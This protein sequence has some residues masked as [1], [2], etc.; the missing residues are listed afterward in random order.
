MANED[1]AGG[2]TSYYRPRAPECKSTFLER[3]VQEIMECERAKSAT[4][5]PSESSWLSEAALGDEVRFLTTGRVAYKRDVKEKVIKPL[6]AE[7]RPDQTQDA[8]DPMPASS[9]ASPQA[10][11]CLM[12]CVDCKIP[13]CGTE[14]L[15]FFK[16]VNQQGGVEVN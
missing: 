3:E 4:E 10:T 2:S 14:D 11:G 13:L 8:H 6:M 16:R 5:L 9:T 15:A 12:Q 1:P 7:Y